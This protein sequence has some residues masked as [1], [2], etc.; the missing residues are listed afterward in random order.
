[1]WARSRCFPQRGTRVWSGQ[2]R[3]RTTE[4]YAPDLQ[5]GPIVHSGN[6]PCTGT[7]RGARRADD[8]TR[9]RNL[10]FTKQLLCQL[11]YV[12]KPDATKSCAN[13][14]YTNGFGERQ[15]EIAG[16]L[17]Q[18]WSPVR[19]RDKSTTQHSIQLNNY[20][21]IISAEIAHGTTTQTGSI[22]RRFPSNDCDE[23][24]CSCRCGP[25][26]SLAHSR[27]DGRSRA[28]LRAPRPH[29][30]PNRLRIVAALDAVEL[31]VCDLSATIGIS[32]SA[33]S[34]QLRQMR[35]L[36]SSVAG[37][38]AGASS[39]PWT[40]EHVMSIYRQARDHVGHGHEV[41]AAV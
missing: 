12:G 6:C 17:R 15:R 34:H 11:S 16:F 3:I 35:E 9:T 37:G 18:P 36:D 25:R 7:P 40:D 27:L 19:H 28:T 8:G 26:G 4:A 39:M 30:R 2:W 14:E 20:S 1:M 13:G 22:F 33:V 38:T 23:R 32:E 5:S 21:C 10:L 24:V 41:E 29:G 31:C